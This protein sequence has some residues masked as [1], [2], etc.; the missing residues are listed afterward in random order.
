MFS[1]SVLNELG[2]E[3]SKKLKSLKHSL[4]VSERKLKLFIRANHLMIEKSINLFK[5]I[6]TTLKSPV[7]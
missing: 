1:F 5:D 3:V 7:K 6:K 2:Q 4:E